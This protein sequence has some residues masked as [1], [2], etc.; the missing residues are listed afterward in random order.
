MNL[1]SI[2][3]L[4]V[5]LPLNFEFKTAKTLLK[6]R[7]TLIIVVQDSDGLRGYGEAVAFTEPFYTNET[8]ASALQVLKN[9]YIPRVLSEKIKHPFDIHNFF[10]LSSPMALAGLENALL[11]LYATKKELNIIE[12]LFDEQLQDHVDVGIVLGDMSYTNLQT[13]VSQYLEQGCT[14][15]KFKIF[16]SEDCSSLKKVQKIR[17]QFPH[18]TMLA[19]ANTSFSFKQSDLEELTLYNNVGFECIEEVF[20]MGNKSISHYTTTD[21]QTYNKVQ[22]NYKIC[23]DESLLS[24]DDMHIAFEHNIL[25]MINIKIG[26]LGGLYYVKQMIDFCRKQN[27]PY[28][29]GSMV[30]SG[31]SK[32]LHVQLAALQGAYIAGDLSDSKRYFEHDLIEPEIISNKGKIKVPRK[33]GLGV[34][35][36]KTMLKKYTKQA[37]TFNI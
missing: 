32:I 14:R 27:I 7:E 31:I 11:D 8:L 37:W 19:D 30:E 36:N 22:F 9:D 29:I 3:I 4:H 12:M 28:F 13:K 15:F 23:H 5:Q 26:R 6:H 24:L 2:K 10:D 17:E 35:V 34:E 33:A 18:I 20:D 16:P 25:Q 21:F 1:Q